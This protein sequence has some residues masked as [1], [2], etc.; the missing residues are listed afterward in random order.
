M[1]K[2]EQ[3]LREKIHTQKKKNCDK[4]VEWFNVSE[5]MKKIM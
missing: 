3:K 4:N 1:G 2:T 5:C